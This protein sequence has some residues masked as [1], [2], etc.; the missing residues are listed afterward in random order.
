MLS[1]MGHENAN[2][3]PQ[4]DDHEEL[5]KEMINPTPTPENKLRK[6]EYYKNHL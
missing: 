1:P 2:K 6:I 5:E 4:A 3:D